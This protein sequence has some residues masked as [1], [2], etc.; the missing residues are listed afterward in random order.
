MDDDAPIGPARVPLPTVLLSMAGLWA[1][2]F[3]LVTARGWLLELEYQGELLALRGAVSLASIAVTV[4]L[5]LVLRGFDD[6]RIGLRVFIALFA[7]LPAALLLAVI[8]QRVFADVEMRVNTRMAEKQGLRMHRDEAGNLL[9]DLP[10]LRAPSDIAPP[11]APSVP[12]GDTSALPDGDTSAPPPPAVP[13]PDD[14]TSGTITIDSLSR[15]EMMWRQLTDIA[16]GRYF[17]LI[18]WAALYIALTQAQNART[19]ERREGEYR[20]AAKA[21]ELRSLRYQVNPHFLFNTLNSLSALVMT[22]R[23]QQAETMIQSIST[24]YRRSL[25]GDPSGDVPLAEEI[26]LQRAYL[27][28]ES[29]R[30]PER[31]HTTFDVPDALGDA[32]VPGMILQPL[33]ENSV[34]YAVAPLTRPVTIRVAAEEEYGRLVLT[35]ADDGPG[36]TLTGA[37]AEGCGIGVDNVRNRLRI[38]YGENATVVSGSTGAGWRTVIRMPLERVGPARRRAE[39]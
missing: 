24:F 7:A 21:A 22:N 20:R 23:A 28:I 27:R 18:A 16:L 6:R 34:K 38:R 5:W 32:R 12:N 33:I 1:C 37:K 9:V 36:D 3:A 35:I 19:A 2:Y 26:E 39:G 11:E 14:A 29:V 17:L 25:S 13:M 8:N 30:F 15:E 4:L 31:L 10:G